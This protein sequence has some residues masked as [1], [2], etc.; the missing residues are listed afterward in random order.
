MRREGEV[1]QLQHSEE[2]QSD[3]LAAQQRDDEDAV[4]DALCCIQELL[5]RDCALALVLAVVESRH[6]GIVLHVQQVARREVKQDGLVDDVATVL[7]HDLDVGS[8]LG[9]GDDMHSVVEDEDVLG[10]LAESEVRAVGCD[11]EGVAAVLLHRDQHS[12]DVESHVAGGGLGSIARPVHLDEAGRG[13]AIATDVVAVIA[14]LVHSDESVATEGT[15]AER[16]EPGQHIAIAHAAHVAFTAQ[17]QVGTGPVEVVVGA[18]VALVA[19]CQRGAVE[20]ASQTAELAQSRAAVQEVLVGLV[21]LRACSQ[22]GAGEAVGQRARV[23]EAVGAVEEVGGGVVAAEAS[24]QIGA[25]QAVRQRTVL[26][27]EGAGVDEGIEQVVAVAASEVGQQVE[28]V[29]VVAGRAGGQGGAGQ[30]V[31]YRTCLA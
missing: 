14:L 5:D 15:A 9:G 18:V 24:R 2:L 31:R 27:G 19:H 3:N 16:G 8:I 29:V 23:A 28:R 10:D 13:A 30:A 25:V 21:A 1:G 6:I 20:T 7:R 22:V 26:A 11:L 4:A 12:R 17:S